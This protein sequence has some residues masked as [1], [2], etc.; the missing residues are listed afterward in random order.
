MAQT[1]LETN[2]GVHFNFSTPGAG[3][4]ALGGAFLALAFDASAA[5]TNPAGLTTIA[6]PEALIEARHWSFTHVFT[7]HGRF[8]GQTPTGQGSD[9]FPGL[10]DGQAED[11]VTGLSFLSY[12]YPYR[13]WSFAVYRHELVNFEANFSVNGAYLAP[14]RGRSPLGIPGTLDGRLAALRNRME[15]DVV[16]YGGSAAYRLGRGFSLGVTASWFDFDID[17]VA[18]RYLPDNLFEPA[19]FR[20]DRL[21]NSQRQQG[22]DGD[23][24]FG[25]GF[26]WE[27]PRKRWSVGG[28]YRQGPDFTFR[29][30]SRSELGELISFAP[31]D[32]PAAFH[33]PDTYGIGV[34]LRPSDSLRLTFDYDRVRYSQTTK[35]F[36][37]IFG[38]AQLSPRQPPELDR[39]V[40]DDADELHLGLEYGFLQRWPVLTVRAGAWYEPDH[41]LRFEGENVGFQA[42][43]R[44]RSDQMHYTAGAGLALRRIQLDAAVDYSDRVS[45]LALS[46]GLRF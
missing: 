8:E 12:V 46:T 13:D 19:N 15:L 22:E 44:Q 23:W 38:L 5:Y 20:S 9:I 39:F 30:R 10:R 21:V 40:T 6:A 27:G 16:A 1:N 11:Q 41:S 35:G 26:L 43:F 3:N 31:Q 7:D 37:D 34:A 2:A 18:W 33:V 45:V 17:S 25:A 14:T 36:V 4:L 32:Q 28:V 42:V 29:A 24:G